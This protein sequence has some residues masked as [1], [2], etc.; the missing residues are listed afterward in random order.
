MS[1]AIAFALVV[2]LGLV[3]RSWSL[4][5]ANLAAL[6]AIVFIYVPVVYSRKRGEDLVDYGF[7]F[8]PIRRGVL[9][10]L[11]GTI[12]ILPLFTAGFIFFYDLVCS[13][14]APT[15]ITSLAPPGFCKVWRGWGG[16]NAPL[17]DFDL[18]KFFFTQII[19]VALP[20][21]LFF[22]GFVHKLLEQK[23]K[24][25]RRFL[26]GGLGVALIVSSALFAVVHMMVLVDPR[27]LAVFFPGLVFGWMRSATGSIFAGVMFHALC[28]TFIKTMQN[29]FF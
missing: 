29:M 21:E 16:A 18:A 6:V 17:I 8:A 7:H 1:C 20:E 24:P 9:Y 10:F 19:V 23:W 14:S 4:L 22:R 12:V 3:A 27:R 26:G 28:N 5:F 15:A 25:K 11:G 13:A 2:V